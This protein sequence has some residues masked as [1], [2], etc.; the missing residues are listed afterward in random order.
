M[1]PRLQHSR[2]SV[3]AFFT[4]HHPLHRVWRSRQHGA[5]LIVSLLML[6]AVSLLGISATQIA[7]QGEKASRSDRDRQIALQAAEAALLDAEMDI[8]SSPDATLSRS[9]K[10]SETP[11][12]ASDFVTGCGAGESSTSL[13]LCNSVEG[14]TTPVWLK[15]DFTD[16][17][18][19]STKS[20]PYGK[21]TGQRMQVEKG[22][23]PYQL[24][25]YIIEVMR[26]KSAKEVAEVAGGHGGNSK[27]FTYFYRVTAMG[28]GAR[29][30]TQVVLQSFYRKVD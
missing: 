28:F 11:A 3:R 4:L 10:F 6:I 13:G 2:D 7:L 5:S 18:A 21:F 16:V 26:Y 27:S 8:K 15:V 9:N 20:V 24:P 30:T 22:L 25:R 14:S 1:K 23:L 12:Y 19:S 29:P 17:A